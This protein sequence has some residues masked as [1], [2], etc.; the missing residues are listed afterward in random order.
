MPSNVLAARVAL[1]SAFEEWEDGIR[2][3]LRAMYGRGEFPKRVNPD[4]LAT[5]LLAAV[6]GG[7]LLTQV[8]R[9][10]AP[11]EHALD[12]MLDDVESLAAEISDAQ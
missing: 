5:A 12:T 9:N 3:R 7:F 1:C 11:L 6:E 10:T 2:R 4:N 8:R